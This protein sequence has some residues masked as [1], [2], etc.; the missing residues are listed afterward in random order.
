VAERLKE[1]P[2]AKV[3]LGRVDLRFSRKAMFDLVCELDS[4][5]FH[6]RRTAN[7]SFVCHDRDGVLAFAFS[8]DEHLPGTSFVMR[9]KKK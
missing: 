7:R 2:L 3:S 8:M 4:A 5:R 9:L 6:V 1:Q